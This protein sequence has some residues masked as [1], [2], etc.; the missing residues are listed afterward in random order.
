M[1]DISYSLKSKYF[2]RYFFDIAVFISVNVIL[3]NLIFGIII[4]AFAG[5]SVTN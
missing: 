5:K 2:V 1:I 4:D 3:M